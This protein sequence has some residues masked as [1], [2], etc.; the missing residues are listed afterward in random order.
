LEYSDLL[1]KAAEELNIEIDNIQIE[2]FDLYMK[3]LLEWNQKV[4][5]TAITEE[6]EIIIKHFI[7]SLT[8]VKYINSGDRVIDVGTGAG[9]PGIPIKMIT[10]NAN[11]VV[12]MDSLNKRIK[13]LN[14]I[15]EE[16]KLEGISTVHGR[17]EDMGNSYQHR[18]A[19]DVVTARAVANLSVLA[20]YCL[21]FAKIGGRMLGMKGGD[22]A[23]E[24]QQAHKAIKILGGEVVTVEKIKLPFSDITH[25][26]V[27]I[28]KVKNTPKN[29][30]RK[31]G[32]PEKEPIDGKCF[33]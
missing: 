6:K 16:L 13:F 27:E 32:T 18:E 23:E 25:S 22:A 8:C 26:I 2:R 21:P 28:M 19:Y 5:L 24:V 11:N 30:P 33:T 31:A 12:L 17:A 7:D 4:N 9:F 29:Y 3:L 14:E 20:E 10:A 1:I 15:I